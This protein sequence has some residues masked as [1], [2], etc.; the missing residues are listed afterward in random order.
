MAQVNV[1]PGSKPR[2]YTV[3]VTADEAVILQR[4]DVNWVNE[5]AKPRTHNDAQKLKRHTEA[6]AAQPQNK[7]S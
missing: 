2:R 4:M 7:R 5:Y 3:S 1:I 6:I